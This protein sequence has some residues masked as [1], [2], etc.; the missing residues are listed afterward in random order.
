RSARAAGDWRLRCREHDVC[1]RTVRL[2]RL[3]LPLGLDSVACVLPERWEAIAAPEGERLGSHQISG[4][5]RRVTWPFQAQ[6][7]PLSSGN[8]LA[9]AAA[10]TVPSS[11]RAACVRSPLR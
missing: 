4:V 2:T 8:R 6:T 3:L 1:G 5:I 9:P 10:V 7:V 11:T